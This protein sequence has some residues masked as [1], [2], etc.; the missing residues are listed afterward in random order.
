[1]TQEELESKANY[2]E[3][4][5]LYPYRIKMDQFQYC[6]E[7]HLSSR[8]DGNLRWSALGY[9]SGISSCLNKMVHDAVK[10]KSYAS[11]KEYVTAL[12]TKIETLKKLTIV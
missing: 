12:T 3:D 10:E 5:Q 7:K 4:L 9:Y 11:L 1:M 6:L 8:K 2:I